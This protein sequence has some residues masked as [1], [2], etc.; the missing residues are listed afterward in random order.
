MRVNRP[1]R[2][3]VNICQRLM[4]HLRSVPS[5][6]QLLEPLTNPYPQLGRSRTRKRYRHDL[7][8][9]NS[10]FDKCHQ[11]RNQRS[12]LAST[13]TGFD[14]DVA[15][16]LPA[17]RDACGIVR[18]GGR[19]YHRPNSIDVPAPSGSTIATYS[20]GTDA[21]LRSQTTS[22]LESHATSKGH[23]LQFSQLPD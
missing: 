18:T 6:N 14:K 3:R 1:E 22:R 7:I 11:S 19:H 2:R 15:L 12:R 4:D 21:R 20:S 10:R 9:T 5:T 13:R 8:N 23:S 17:D 16:Q